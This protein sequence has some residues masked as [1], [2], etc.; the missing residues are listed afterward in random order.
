MLSSNGGDWR[1]QSCLCLPNVGF[2]ARA[3]MPCWFLPLSCC[4]G[5]VCC[6]YDYHLTFLIAF[7]K[8]FSLCTT[9]ENICSSSCGQ[10]QIFLVSD[11]LGEMSFTLASS[12]CVFSSA[13]TESLKGSTVS[14]CSL[15]ITRAH[16][17]VRALYVEKQVSE[18]I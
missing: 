13:Q 11:S 9:I 2:W 15:L 17:I 6:A 10:C 12:A 8:H 7:H 3:A 14:L 16:H 18:R 4:H 1:W 5:K